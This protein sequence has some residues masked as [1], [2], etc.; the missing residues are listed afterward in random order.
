MLHVKLYLNCRY[1]LETLQE[2][3]EFY[4][5]VMSFMDPCTN[6]ELI[7]NIFEINLKFYGR[8]N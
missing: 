4:F 3:T 5:R 8:S 7:L 1:L 6:F 2:V